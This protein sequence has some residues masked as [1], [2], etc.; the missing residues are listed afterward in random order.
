MGTRKIRKIAVLGSGLMGSG[1][2][3][4]FAGS[5]FDVLLLDLRNQTVSYKMLY[6]NLYQQNLLMY[7]T[8]VHYLEFK[9][10]TLMMI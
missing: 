5:G 10:A 1:I 9:P 4:H 2:A 8:K 7:Y 3:L 6:K